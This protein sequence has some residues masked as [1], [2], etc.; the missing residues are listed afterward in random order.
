MPRRPWAAACSQ[1]ART[2]VAELRKN[3]SESDPRSV[4]LS[5]PATSAAARRCATVWSRQ[6]GIGFQWTVG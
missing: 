4:V 2:S 5:T 3:R 6:A 1:A